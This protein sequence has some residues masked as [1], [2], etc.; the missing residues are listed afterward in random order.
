MSAKNVGFMA[1]SVASPSVFLPLVL[2]AV[3]TGMMVVIIPDPVPVVIGKGKDDRCRSGYRNTGLNH[4]RT[5]NMS[6]SMAIMHNATGGKDGCQKQ[7]CYN[8]SRLRSSPCVR[9]L[10][11]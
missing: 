3:M 6:T 7:D 5:Y 10:V 2:F 1:S 11:R 8:R 9:G 4:D